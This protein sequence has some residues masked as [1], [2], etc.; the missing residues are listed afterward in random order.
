[1]NKFVP[2]LQF[3]IKLLR[4][5]C[6]EVEI[7]KYFS[8]IFFKQTKTISVQDISQSFV[9][10]SLNLHLKDVQFWYKDKQLASTSGTLRVNS[11]GVAELAF[12]KRVQFS[13]TQDFNVI[14]VDQDIRIEASFQD[15]VIH[16]RPS[17]NFSSL[18]F[19]ADTGQQQPIQFRKVVF[20]PR[21]QIGKI[22]C[23]E[24]FVSSIPIELIEDEING[25]NYQG[26]QFRIEG[27]N[28]NN[29]PYL[30]IESSPEKTELELLTAPAALF[31]LA[32][33]GG[34][35]CSWK[36][37]IETGT[38]GLKKLTLYSAEPI[39]TNF[40]AP[41]QLSVFNGERNKQ[42]FF[43]VHKFLCENPDS[44]VVR[45]YGMLWNSTGSD[46][47]ARAVLLGIAIEGVA[48]SI[49]ITKP[50]VTEYNEFKMRIL[51][52]LKP[53]IEGQKSIEGLSQNDVRRLVGSFENSKPSNTKDQI[54]EACKA[55]NLSISKEQ[56]SA[57]GKLRNKRGHGKF[58]YF[59][60]DEDWSVYLKCVD[61]FNHLCLSIMGFS[62]QK[63]FRR[64]F[65]PVPPSDKGKS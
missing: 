15:F 37:L 13:R 17:I 51:T 23:A 26:S 9:D 48:N 30:K 28:K 10:S 3:I 59:A 8:N 2:M 40:Y 61:I 25:F 18:D 7:V 33:L 41:L 64:W 22:S 36:T 45:M 43:Q 65:R 57:W 54:E 24:G 63:V 55:V 50:E 21:R 5:M 53:L 1:M 11:E 39:T 32:I 52:A 58:G 47:D 46:F 19:F 44:P 14:E 27:T 29:G 20:E 4:Q 42:I 56:L 12:P 31:S 62:D 60:T 34:R 38:S 35:K 49:K 6:L 16:A